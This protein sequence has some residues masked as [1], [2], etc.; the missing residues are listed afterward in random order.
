MNWA[1]EKSESDADNSAEKADQNIDMHNTH[2][3]TYM[4]THRIPI[5]QNATRAHS[6]KGEKSNKNVTPNVMETRTKSASYF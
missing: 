4:C 3:H 1:V 5:H 2:T 6:P